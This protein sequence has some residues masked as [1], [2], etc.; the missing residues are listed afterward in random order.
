MIGLILAC[1]LFLGV[2]QGADSP[3]A[4]IEEYQ[5][6]LRDKKWDLV[7]DWQ[8]PSDRQ[9]IEKEFREKKIPDVAQL[10]KL[11]GMTEEEL[12]KLTPRQFYTKLPQKLEEMEPGYFG[13][14]ANA[15]FEKKSKEGEDWVY[16]HQEKGTRN[17]I[18]TT[19]RVT[20]IATKEA[21][22]WY[23][24]QSLG[25]ERAK[26]ASNEQ[27][28]AGTLRSLALAEADFKAEDRDGDGKKNFWVADVRGLFTLK[29][30]DGQAI[31]LI[32]VEAA[33]ADTAL[34]KLSP[35]LPDPKAGPKAGYHYA[36]LKTY[37]K[38]GKPTPYDEGKGR[39]EMHFGLAAYPE[40]VGSTGRFTFLVN[41]DNVVWKKDTGG[42][43]PEAFPEDP[44]KDGW[45]RSE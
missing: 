8:S 4:A 11:L 27:N 10:T 17:G 30:K 25:E 41:E 16:E 18:P 42:K 15:K 9:R 43:L 21:G 38:K 24:S 3:D 37:V 20:M 31:R 45:E 35:E 26:R 6:A 33:A 1:S 12:F 19:S 29:G 5:K 32:E 34:S 23:V 39:S 2:A 22:K 36:A 7:Y 28:A 40:K 44:A 14:M 13:I